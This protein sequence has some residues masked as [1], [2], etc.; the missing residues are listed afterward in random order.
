MALHA[1]EYQALGASVMAVVAQRSEKVKRYIEDTGLPFD[2]LIDETRDTAKAYGVWQRIGFDA[3]N[4]AR[5]SVFIIDRRG[6][7]RYVFVADFQTEFPEQSVIIDELK[8]LVGRWDQ[9]TE[10]RSQET[11]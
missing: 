10:D 7:I 1:K 5:P 8:A 11:E 3:W 6:A 4:I 9:K 2:I